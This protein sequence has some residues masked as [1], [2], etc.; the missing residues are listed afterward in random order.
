MGKTLETKQS[1]YKSASLYHVYIFL[2]KIATEQTAQNVTVMSFFNFG[3]KKRLQARPPPPAVK[4]T[5][6]LQVGGG[7]WEGVGG[8]WE[9]V[10]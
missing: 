10:G 5:Q 6:F 3:L 7:G 2:G 9:G 8:G 1:N 4:I